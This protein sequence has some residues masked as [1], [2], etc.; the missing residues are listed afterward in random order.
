MC[1]GKIDPL[2][3]RPTEWSVCLATSEVCILS[4]VGEWFLKVAGNRREGHGTLMK[5]LLAVTSV[6]SRL[7][8]LQ[9]AW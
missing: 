4:L 6:T 3:H 5:N 7:P 8:L 9:F 1:H 2:L